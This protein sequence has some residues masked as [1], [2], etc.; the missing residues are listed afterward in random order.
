MQD[1]RMY[2]VEI[3]ASNPDGTI[4]Q[5]LA[6]AE[7]VTAFNGETAEQVAAFAATNQDIADGDHWRVRVW[8]GRDADTGAEPAAE[9]YGCHMGS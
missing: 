7:T 9:F 1:N 6:P 2:T 8:E 3:E 4:W 5:A